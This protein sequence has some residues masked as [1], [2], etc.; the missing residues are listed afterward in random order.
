MIRLLSGSQG[1][2]PDHMHVVLGNGADPET[3]SVHRYLAFF[4]KVQREFQHAN[5]VQAETYP[6]PVDHCRVCAWFSI[7]DD[8]WRADDHLSFVAGISSTAGENWRNCAVIS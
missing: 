1:V 6:E 4:R 2:M 7:C 5:Q 8:L 3:F